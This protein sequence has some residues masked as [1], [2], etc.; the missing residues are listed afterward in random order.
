MFTNENAE[1]HIPP[2]V[3]SQP[4]FQS[5][6][7]LSQPNTLEHIKSCFREETGWEI[8]LVRMKLDSNIQP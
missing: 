6:G 5:R 1:A 2:K 4:E 3:G 8:S 7:S